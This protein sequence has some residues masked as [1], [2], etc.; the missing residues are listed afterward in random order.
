[1]PDLT[2]EQCMS[3]LNRAGLRLDREHESVA[4]RLVYLNFLHGNIPAHLIA[5]CE[6][7]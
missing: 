4:R 2:D 7:P 6:A 3:V 1:M 5:N